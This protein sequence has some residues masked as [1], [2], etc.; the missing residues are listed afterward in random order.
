[1][2]YLRRL[3]FPVR[4]QH[5]IYINRLSGGRP[6]PSCDG[7]GIRSCMRGGGGGPLAISNGRSYLQL[8]CYRSSL[9]PFLFSLP[10]QSSDWC[11]PSGSLLCLLLASL[12]SC[13]YTLLPPL[14]LS[15]PLLLLLFPMP[16]FLVFALRSAQHNKLPTQM[17][18]PTGRSHQ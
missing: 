17:D 7:S 3:V 11:H 8:E 5:M 4:A 13:Q 2:A 15:L 12:L 1:M 9:S 14:L 16:I 6:L 10:Q 18:A